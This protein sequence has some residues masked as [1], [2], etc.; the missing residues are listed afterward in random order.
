MD[1]KGPLPSSSKNRYI[2]TIID[3]YSRFPFAFACPN[4]ETS[5]VIKCL[6]QL[7]AIFGMP[8]YIHSDRGQSLMAKELKDHLH[9]LGIATSRTTSYNPQG[10][11][12][13]ER[14][15]RVIWK[16]IELALKSHH[17][18]NSQWEIVLMEALHSIRFL[19]CTSTNSTPHERM[20]SHQRQS[21]SGTSIP[22]WLSHPG[23]VLLKR[24]VKNSKYDFDVDEVDLIEANPQYGYV[25]LN[26][27]C[28][29]TISTRYL[30]PTGDSLRTVNSNAGETLRTVN[31]TNENY[32]PPTL[33]NK[34][35]EKGSAPPT[36]ENVALT[37]LAGQFT[38]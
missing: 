25:R 22:S 26:N 20:F 31:D 27:G 17:Y 15:N 7:F 19:L 35:N 38:E 16:T 23:K 8:N 9:N 37:D 3:E 24:H 12:Q 18:P 4:L 2:L 33:C 1:F 13:C 34:P 21:S 14:Y 11:G 28:E 29:T 32:L 5:T 10:N 6:E 36:D 30:A